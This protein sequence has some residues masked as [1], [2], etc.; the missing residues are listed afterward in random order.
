MRRILLLALLALTACDSTQPALVVPGVYELSEWNG[1]PV[2]GDASWRDTFGVLNRRQVIRGTMT[3]R[4]DGTFV[5][6][7]TFEA[8]GAWVSSHSG[9]FTEQGGDGR[10]VRLHL[11]DGVGV[12]QWDA[13]LTHAGVSFAE[14]HNGA[15][16]FARQ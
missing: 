14:M 2:P 10:S 7:V 11:A 13:D 1:Q 5:H 12:Y 3:I 8:G 9:T 4:E 6:S 15:A 16:F